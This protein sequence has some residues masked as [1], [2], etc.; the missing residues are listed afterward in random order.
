MIFLHGCGSDAPT[1]CSEIFE[2]QDSNE[3]TLT[4]LFPSIKWVFPCAEK[5]YAKT[6][7]EEMHQWFDM[8]SVQRPQEDI[9]TQ[10][11]GLWESVKKV[12]AILKQEAEI[13]GSMQNVIV[14]GI[15]Q[16]CATAM[17]AL[18]T[19]GVCAGGFFG[20]CGWL[21]L[22]EEI[23]E[24]MMVPGRL[25]DVLRT[26][27]LLQHCRDDNVV[28]VEIGEGFVEQ[29][30]RL[31]IQTKWECFADGGHWLQEPTGMDGIVRF[32]N[33]VMESSKIAETGV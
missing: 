30:R 9:N 1:F 4:Q 5:T 33:N 10:K 15:S 3:R 23:Q 25:K 24:L 31:G 21:P 27:V 2:S 8:V 14:A 19:S 20:L 13:V 29:L 32:I 11:M 16:G 12:L 6:E 17:F 22:A 18:L 26:P 7:D 28:P